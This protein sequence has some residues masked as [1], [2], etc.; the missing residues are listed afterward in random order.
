MNHDNGDRHLVSH[1]K[2]HHLVSDNTLHVIGVIENPMR[3]HSRYRLFREWY[4]AMLETPNVKVYVVEIAYGD[5]HFE[6]TEKC[7]PQHLQLHSRQPIWHKESMINLAVKRLFPKDWKYMCW[8]DCDIFFDHKG[9][10]LETIHQMQDYSV[11]QPWSDALDLGFHGRVL[12]HFKSFCYQHQRGVP[13]Q[14]H[15][16]QPYE[17]AHSGFCWAARRD[18]YESVQ[19]LMD[20]SILGSADHHMAFALINQVDRTVKQGMHKNFFRLCEEWEYRA[21]RHTNGHLGYVPGFIK[22]KH[23]GPKAKR[24]YR[25]RWDI[26]I[27]NHYDPIVDLVHDT[28]GLVK[29][30]GKPHLIHEC[31]KYMLSRHEDS[32]EDY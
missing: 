16:S 29:L 13:K 32:T 2:N 7:N 11:V 26:L 25:E 14:T 28:Q 19:G 18:F 21:Y 12:K 3:Y 10:A 31:R 17:Y 1:I 4:K 20:F 24:Y 6:V 27:S 23:H 30:V 9:W 5:R 22:H 8:S 15:P